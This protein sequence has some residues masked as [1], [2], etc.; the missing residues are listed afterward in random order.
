MSD[1][2]RKKREA[3]YNREYRREHAQ[4][5]K[6]LRHK[7]YLEEKKRKEEYRREHG[8]QPSDVERRKRQAEYSRRYRRNNPEKM[9]EKRHEYYLKHK[10]KHLAYSRKYV[11]EHRE[12]I[13]EL[14]R[15]RQKENYKK[16]KARIAAG[17]EQAIA[18]AEER[19]AKRREYQRKYRE[20]QREI[21]SAYRRQHGGIN[22]Q[23]KD[24]AV[25]EIL[26]I[27]G[28]REE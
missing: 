27:L 4:R 15:V 3:E 17:D 21:I 14:H 9:K 16:Q 1:E 28:M 24:E 18:R 12:R 23:A 8:E 25:N 5:M 19:L 7:Y 2:E 11:I 13:N 10:E 6:E 26:T 20:K 22:E